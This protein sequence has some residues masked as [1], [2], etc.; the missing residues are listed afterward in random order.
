MLTLNWMKWPRI[1]EIP[2]PI[3]KEHVRMTFMVSGGPSITLNQTCICRTV[4]SIHIMLTLNW[5]KWRWLNFDASEWNGVGK[6]NWL[7]TTPFTFTWNAFPRSPLPRP[8]SFYSQTARPTAGFIL[9][10]RFLIRKQ[11]SSM[12]IW[13]PRLLRLQILICNTKIII[14]NTH[15]INFNTCSGSRSSATDAVIVNAVFD[16]ASR[17]IA[18]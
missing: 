2:A 16:F 15:F 14:L 12:I 9:K 7:S 18:R 6:M 10:S 5:T 3:Y 13:D 4:W 1:E 17:F 11:D 8:L